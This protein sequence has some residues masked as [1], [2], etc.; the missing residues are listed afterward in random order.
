MCLVYM[1]FFEVYTFVDWPY[2]K[3]ISVLYRYIFV[4]K[5]HVLFSQCNDLMS[6][7]INYESLIPI[8]NNKN[9]STCWLFLQTC[10]DP[11]F[12]HIK[13]ASESWP[14]Y[15]CMFGV[16]RPSREIS[17][18]VEISSLPVKSFKVWHILGTHDQG[19]VMV[20]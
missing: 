8:V 6:D 4:F 19:P 9:K 17:Y 14:F 2:R 11:F 20:L 7:L 13:Y 5:P 3:A 15:F 18:H 10:V 16:M 12:D 1:Q